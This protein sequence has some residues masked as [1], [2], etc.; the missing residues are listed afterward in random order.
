MPPP[1]RRAE[2]DIIFGQ[3][4]SNIG[5][6]IDLA[7]EMGILKRR[8]S[9]Y[10]YKEEN[11]AQGR[12]NLVVYLKENPEILA[13]VE[14]AVREKLSSGVPVSASQPGAMEDGEEE[15]DGAIFEGDEEF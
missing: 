2:F 13:E 7:D 12:D 6:I 1:F 4:I 5:C 9:W 3:G 10:S 8:G 11:V 15:I 14:G